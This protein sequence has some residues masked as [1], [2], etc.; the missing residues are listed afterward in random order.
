MEKQPQNCRNCGAPYK[1]PAC[2][3][4]GT[5]TLAIRDANAK[6]GAWATYNQHDLNAVSESLQISPV[7]LLAGALLSLRFFAR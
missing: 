5:I 2:A 3:Y 6:P 7:F 1:A 4:C